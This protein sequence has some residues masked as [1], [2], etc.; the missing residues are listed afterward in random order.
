MMCTQVTLLLL[1]IQ[2]YTVAS[3]LHLKLILIEVYKT[4]LK[5]ASHLAVQGNLTYTA[6]RLILCFAP[7]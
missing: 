2:R 6:E 5:L 3:W 1:Q 7:Q 4:M